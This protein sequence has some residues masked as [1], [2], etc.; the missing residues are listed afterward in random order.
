MTPRFCRPV[1][2]W[3]SPA[4]FVL[5]VLLFSIIMSFFVS[6]ASGQIPSNGIAI[7]EALPLAAQRCVST[8]LPTSKGK[9]IVL[10][11][12]ATWCS[13]CIAMIPKMRQLE[14]TF[15][16]EVFFLPV[17]TQSKKEVDVFRRRYNQRHKTNY[18]PAEMVADTLFSR[19]FPHQTLPHY[20]WI[21]G[22]G[23]V[24]AFTE[25]KEITETN[26]RRLL[27]ENQVSLAA[28]KEEPPLPINMQAPFL[29]AGNGGEGKNLIYHSLL[30]AYTP[31]LLPGGITA[32]DSLGMRHFSKNRTLSRLFKIAYSE[33]GQIFDQLNT[34]LEVKD[35]SKLTSKLSGQD[36]LDYLQTGNGYCYELIVPKNLKKDFY[37]LMQQDLDRLFPAYKASVEAR[38]T[39]CL[40]LRRTTNEEKL[41]L[42]KSKKSKVEHDHF[43]YRLENASF[44]QLFYQLNASGR[45][46]LFLVDDTGFSRK[47]DVEIPAPVSDL[48]TFN[49][50][51][52]AYG[53]ELVPEE[54]LLPTLVIQDR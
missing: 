52:S 21:D 43:G 2:L 13:P 34:R 35:V 9:I 36:Y 51:V 28:K 19:L 33:K 11:F 31:G 49:A 7:G 24:R 44:S 48:K 3:L 20:V 42:A 12:W 5:N 45:S 8:Q 41:P 46:P 39:Q 22:R 1:L 32:R 50:I 30:T 27:Q 29:V 40:V 16:G 14:H 26:I 47:T 15:Q 18:V 38:P 6:A 37:R 4:L 10:D 54:R 17:T 53:L 25:P 23:I